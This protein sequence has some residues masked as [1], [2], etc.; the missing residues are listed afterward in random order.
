[1]RLRANT[2]RGSLGQI[3]FEFLLLLHFF[4]DLLSKVN[5]VSEQIQDPKFRFGEGMPTYIHT[6]IRVRMSKEFRCGQVGMSRR[7]MLQEM[8]H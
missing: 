3:D 8:Q 1:M 6:S 2:A 7:Y 5:K 4:A